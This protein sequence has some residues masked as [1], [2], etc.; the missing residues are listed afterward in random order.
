[1]RQVFPQ[2]TPRCPVRVVEIIEPDFMVTLR[3]DYQCYQ[4][5]S[6]NGEG[7]VCHRLAHGYHALPGV[8]IP[9]AEHVPDALRSPFWHNGSQIFSIVTE[10]G[11]PQPEYLAFEFNPSS[12]CREGGE[13]DGVGRR[14]FIPRH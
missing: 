10:E 9:D 4:H 13:E 6:A 11:W 5:P 1:M 3:Y 7:R 12:R 2:N 14:R 8:H